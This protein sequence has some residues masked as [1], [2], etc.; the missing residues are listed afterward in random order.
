MLHGENVGIYHQTHSKY[1]SLIFDD[2]HIEAQL[3][4]ICSILEQYNAKVMDM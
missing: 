3:R 2:V 1:V 4:K